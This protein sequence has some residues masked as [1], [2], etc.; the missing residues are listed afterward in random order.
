[1]ENMRKCYERYLDGDFLNG[2]AEMLV[3]DIGGADINGSYREIFSD[4][5]FRY[6]AADVS[7]GDGVELVLADPYHIPMADAS[8]DV[9]TSGQ[10]PMA[11]AFSP[12]SARTA[13]T[14]RSYP[15]PTTSFPTT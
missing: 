7:E 8:V 6:V 4:P 2:R 3:L 11:T 12:S 1:M 15:P 14:W 5:R 13:G 9:V 10:M